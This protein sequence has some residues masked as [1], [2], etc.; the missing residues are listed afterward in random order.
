MKR[1]WAIGFN[2]NKEHTEGTHQM[3][4]LGWNCCWIWDISKQIFDMT[5]TANRCAHIISMKCNKTAVRSD[6]YKTSVVY[7]LY[8]TNCEENWLLWTGTFCEYT[9]YINPI[10]FLFSDTAWF[11]C[12]GYVKSENSRYFLHKIPG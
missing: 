10:F 12:D 4:K 2:L 1:V 5:S 7:K 3:T 11:H 6:L 9:R 8:N